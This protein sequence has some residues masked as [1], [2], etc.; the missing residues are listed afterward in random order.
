[1]ADNEELATD[2]TDRL[3]DAQQRLVEVTGSARSSG[4]E[5]RVTVSAGGALQRLSFGQEAERLPRN[6]LATL[7][8]ATANKA[9]TQAAT[10]V[11]SIVQELVGDNTAAMRFAEEQISP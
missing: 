3:A 4:G 7:I 8:V 2:M 10:Q 11:M 6:Q 5:V 9:Q 1:M